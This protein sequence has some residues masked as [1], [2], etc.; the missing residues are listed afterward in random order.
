MSHKKR[1][2]TKLLAGFLGI[3]HHRER[4]RVRRLATTGKH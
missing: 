3:E 4:A 2:R 1:G